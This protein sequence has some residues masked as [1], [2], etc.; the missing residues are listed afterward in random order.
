MLK[1]PPNK[2]I[3]L[4][5]QPK[6]VFSRFYGDQSLSLRMVVGV[7]REGEGCQWR[8]RMYPIKTLLKCLLKCDQPAQRGVADVTSSKN[9]IQHPEKGMTHKS[10]RS[11]CYTVSGQTFSKKT[12]KWELHNHWLGNPSETVTL[13]YSE[14]HPRTWKVIWKGS[15]NPILRGLTITIVIN[16]VLT[17]VILHVTCTCIF[18]SH[19]SSRHIT[20]TCCDSA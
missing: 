14:E 15:H 3:Q 8:C 7:W 11:Y 1:S 17:G 12:I 13:M 2:Y 6:P 20:S 5:W 10:I 9:S 4:C 19:L 18:A 16:H